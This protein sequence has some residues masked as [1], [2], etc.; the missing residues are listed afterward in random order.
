VAASDNSLTAINSHFLRVQQAFQYPATAVAAATTTALP[1]SPT[2]NN[3][4]A[5][6]GATLTASTA[7]PLTI[8]GV[9]INALAQRALINN[10]AASVQ[11][12]CYT[13][14]TVGTISVPYVLTRCADFSTAASINAA[15]VIPV[16][17][18]TA[19]AGT[20]WILAAAD[21]PVSTIGSSPI[22]YETQPKPANNPTY[23]A[24]NF[25]LVPAATGDQGIYPTMPFACSA[26]L[27]WYLTS[28]SGTAGSI[29]ISLYKTNGAIPSLSSTLVSASAPMVLSSANWNATISP[30]TGSVSTWTPLNIAP[31]D[32]FLFDVTS[33]STLTGVSGAIWCQ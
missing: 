12:G 17:A 10:Q 1:D 31:G 33:Y 19:N 27:G 28:A 3:G 7:A 25:T 30:G 32:T 18:G 29:S 15:G 9:S 6:A 24:M 22:G 4:T 2:Y 11:N 26:I 23:H 20:Y 8:D 21:S 14:T 5:G 13:A 16:T